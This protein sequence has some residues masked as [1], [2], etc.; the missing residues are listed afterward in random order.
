MSTYVNYRN[1]K[2]IL[3]LL[4]SYCKITTSSTNIDNILTFKVDGHEI[5]R[6][7]SP[8]IEHRYR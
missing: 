2:M 4:K 6:V 8:L 5:I 7:L 1:M 3:T